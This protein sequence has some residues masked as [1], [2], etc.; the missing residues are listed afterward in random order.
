MKG[1]RYDVKVRA[2][3]GV[4]HSKT[5]ATKKAAQEYEARRDRGPCGRSSGLPPSGSTTCVT[6]QLQ[7][8]CFKRL[9]SAV[10]VSGLS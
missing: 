8:I 1:R 2:G 5:F 7:G 6:P 4:Q 9:A 10:A 3:D